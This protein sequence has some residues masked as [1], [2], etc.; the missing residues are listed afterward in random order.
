MFWIVAEKKE[1]ED[2]RYCVHT[3]KVGNLFRFLKLWLERWIFPWLASLK[4][5]HH[6]FCF[7]TTLQ[8]CRCDSFPVQMNLRVVFFRSWLD[9][10]RSLMEQGILEDDQLLLRFKYYTFFD[11]NP[12]V[13]ALFLLLLTVWLLSCQGAVAKRY[14]ILAR[15]CHRPFRDQTLILPPAMAALFPSRHR[16]TIPY[17]W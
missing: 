4:A 3:M 2:F 1:K 16:I 10:S 17:L 7:V 14:W 6:H 5:V 12:K 13:R 15:I 8:L 11:L 9:S